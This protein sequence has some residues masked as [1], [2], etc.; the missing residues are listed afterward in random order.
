[1]VPRAIEHSPCS[2]PIA[3]K[4]SQSIAF[5]LEQLD[6][7]V[8]FELAKGNLTKADEYSRKSLE[9]ATSWKT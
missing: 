4:E 9:L 1:V 7:L 2:R 3:L 5:S 6:R 8:V